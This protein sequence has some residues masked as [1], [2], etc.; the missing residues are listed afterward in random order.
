[1]N[2]RKKKILII[3]GDDV[4]EGLADYCYIV[5]VTPIYGIGVKLKKV[6][7]SSETW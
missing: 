3:F 2:L 5:S 1:M 7:Y 4:P 6:S